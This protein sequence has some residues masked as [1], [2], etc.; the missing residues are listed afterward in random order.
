[1]SVKTNDSRTEN[2]LEYSAA[3]PLAIAPNQPHTQENPPLL[4]SPQV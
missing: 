3:P 1:M 2:K 4:T